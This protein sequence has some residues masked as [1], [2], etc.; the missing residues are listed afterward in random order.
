[1]GEEVPPP[2]RNYRQMVRVIR[3]PG[4]PGGNASQVPY[5]LGFA[6]SQASDS[7]TQTRERTLDE[8]GIDSRTPRRPE[9]TG[10]ENYA[11]RRETT[12]YFHRLTPAQQLYFTGTNPNPAPSRQEGW[13]GTK[14]R[15]YLGSGVAAEQVIVSPPGSAATRGQHDA[16]SAATTMPSPGFGS[17]IT[18]PQTQSAQWYP[19]KQTRLPIINRPSLHGMQGVA[20]HFTLRR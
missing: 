10:L 14:T 13:P 11:S 8:I 3:D 19:G 1:V 7:P 9:S 6:Y 17:P 18:P 20:I 15:A 12:A 16:Q 5:K 2:Q 4:A